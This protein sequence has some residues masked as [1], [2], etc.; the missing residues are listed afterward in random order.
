[1][2]TK[3]LTLADIRVSHTGSKVSADRT[4]TFDP[5]MKCRKGGYILTYT[6]ATPKSGYDINEVVYGLMVMA[7]HDM[8]DLGKTL[9]KGDFTASEMAGKFLSLDQFFDNESSDYVRY[10]RIVIV[11]P[12]FR[13]Q[14][15]ADEVFK[16]IAEFEGTAEIA[17][18]KMHKFHCDGQDFEAGEKLK[19]YKRHLGYK[20]TTISFVQ[21]HERIAD[22]FKTLG[23]MTQSLT[24]EGMRKAYSVLKAVEYYD[25]ASY[26][27]REMAKRVMTAKLWSDY[28]KEGGSL[29]PVDFYKSD[30]C[31]A[32]D[33]WKTVDRDY[34][35]KLQRHFEAALN[36]QP[37]PTNIEEGMT[38]QF[39]NRA[40]MTKKYQGKYFVESVRQHVSAYGERIE[41]K[42]AL[43][44]TKYN[45]EYFYPDALEEYVKPKKQPKKTVKKSS[46]ESEKK[47]VEEPKPQIHL[48]AEECLRKAILMRLAAA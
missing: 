5:L 9:F 37:K 46:K 26:D 36:A 1:M 19:P 2:E 40:N 31:D 38:V 24:N 22:K 47:K 7:G 33:V 45:T 18:T 21:Y 15:P 27:I 34:V 13:C 16:Y 20:P 39:K 43:R 35:N 14:F 11:T 8:L 6:L 10:D 32:P 41:W 30:F 4:T 42:A 48:S 25:N 29:D 28:R 23:A 17:K 44:I 3:K 12:T